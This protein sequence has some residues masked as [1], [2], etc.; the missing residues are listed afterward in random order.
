[1]K[2]TPV[3]EPA[4]IGLLLAGLL[5]LAGLVCAKEKTR[6]RFVRSVTV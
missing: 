1:M 5:S 2:Y 4:T 3:P 6:M